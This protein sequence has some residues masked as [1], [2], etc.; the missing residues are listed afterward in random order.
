MYHY[1]WGNIFLYCYEHQID[2]CNVYE[3]INEA[4]VETITRCSDDVVWEGIIKNSFFSTIEEELNILINQFNIPP[5]EIVCPCNREDRIIKIC[6][7]LF[8]ENEYW[9]WYDDNP[10]DSDDPNNKSRS[11]CETLEVETNYFG[12]DLTI[13]KYKIPNKEKFIYSIEIDLRNIRFK[14][15]INGKNK[16]VELL[17]NDGVGSVITLF[18]SSYNDPSILP[19]YIDKLFDSH[20][21]Y[22]KKNNQMKDEQYI[23]DFK[24]VIIKSSI[25][26]CAKDNH[27][28]CIRNALIYILDNT[29]Y[30]IIP[31]TVPLLYCKTCNIYY[32]YED[33]YNTLSK[34]GKIL[35]RIYNLKQWQEGYT[36]DDFFGKLNMESVFLDNT[37]Y[38]IVPETV[39]LLYCKTC[40]I[41]YMYEDQYNTL[42][43]KG[44]I[45]CRIYNLKQWQEGYTCD[46]FFGKLNME[47]IF[48]ICGYSVSSN[49]SIPDQARQNLLS[50][51]IDRK[52]VSLAQTLNFLHWLIDNRKD[53]ARMQNAVKKWKSDLKYITEKYRDNKSKTITVESIIRK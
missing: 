1:I 3:T 13:D 6:N 36:G 37:T 27:D 19:E 7:E 40:N 8:P 2:F 9:T 29:T 5:S 48:K 34:K 43:K 12:T 49:S 10:W 32:M 47:S 16:H 33:Q 35:C 14:R 44:K 21:E 4:I 26:Q 39:P 20:D 15:N 30:E 42:S 52:I 38:E 51:L 31:E 45:L 24:N 25:H 23:L 11:V 17:M 18:D 50:F 53:S 28:T 22:L 41:Y 46:D